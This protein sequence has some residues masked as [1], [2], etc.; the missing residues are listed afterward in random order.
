MP[1][2]I[3]R[4]PDMGVNVQGWVADDPL[5]YGDDEYEA[6]TCLACT[7]VHMVNPKTSNVL[8]GNDDE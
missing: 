5:S 7:R 8:G 4:C 2:F 3:F 1:A 6:V